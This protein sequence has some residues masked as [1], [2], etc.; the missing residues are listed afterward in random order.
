M[1]IFERDLG[2]AVQTVL[3]IP[4]VGR[5]PIRCY[6]VCP[7]LAVGEPEESVGG[8]LKK[9]SR[10]VKRGAK[11]IARNKA[12]QEAAKIIDKVAQ[13]LPPPYGEAYATASTTVKVGKAIAER[14]K[15]GDKRAKAA[16]SK[17]RKKKAYK[18]ATKQALLK[19]MM[20]HP[21]GPA[22][23]KAVVKIAKKRGFYRVTTPLGK[24]VEVP[25]RKVKAA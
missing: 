11:K 18:K 19:A 8:F 1:R 25:V 20:A 15:K 2:D 21:K 3:E 22:R 13:G 16:L 23:K 9:F 7:Y 12:L 4:Q 17:L 10:K 24:V 5:E 14:V 6:G